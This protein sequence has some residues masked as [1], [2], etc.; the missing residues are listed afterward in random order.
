MRS[1][2]R[3]EIDPRR[4]RRTFQDRCD[5][6]LVDVGLYRAV[7]FH[8][9]AEAHFDG[10]PYTARRGVNQWIRAGALREHTVHGPKGSPYKLLTPTRS[11][12][13]L[14]RR[15]AVKHGLDAH[16]RTWAGLVKS[17][18]LAHDTQVY[19]AARAEVKRLQGDGAVI[20]RIRI[21]AE[22]KSIVAKRSETARARDGKA[23][24][25]IERIQAAKELSLPVDETG[26][27]HY[28]DAQI[29]YT[30]AEGRTDHVN[31]EVATRDYRNRAIQA[32]AAA[33][34][35]IHGNGRAGARVS[36]A[37]GRSGSKGIRGLGR[38]GDPPAGGTRGPADQGDASVDL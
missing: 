12:A 30:D 10:H 29:E 15:Q 1:G 25:D 2:H 7:S 31:V 3:R 22:L 5:R 33:G 16:Q 37:L 28:P 34:F 17:A 24:A 13:D 11:G 38:R 23:A 26:K 18:E 9:L 14:A 21:D 32:K 8:D 6:A 20:R 4:D 36:K 19:R 27:V 35:V